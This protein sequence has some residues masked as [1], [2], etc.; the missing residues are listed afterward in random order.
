MH[1]EIGRVGAVDAAVEVE[2]GDARR[3]DRD[4]H[5]VGGGARRHRR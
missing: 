4:D 2:V 3:G 1:V 5:A